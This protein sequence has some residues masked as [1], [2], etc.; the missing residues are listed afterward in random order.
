MLGQ[1][2][3]AME[4]GHE[5]RCPPRKQRKRVVVEMKV[6]E[7]EIRRSPTNLLEHR[8]MQGIR[9]AH[10]AVQ[11]QRARPAWHELCRCVRVTAGEQRDVVTERDELLSEPGDDPFGTT[12]ELGRDSLGQWS[13]LRNSHSHD[14]SL[15]VSVYKAR[16]RGIGDALQT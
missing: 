6:Q 9:V 11:S 3:S 16:P 15:S 4:R 8:E 2:K 1:I 12:I 7:V 14:L 13:N 5:G 10:I